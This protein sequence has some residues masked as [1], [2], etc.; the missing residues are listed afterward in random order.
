M[1]PW[2]RLLVALLPAL[3]SG[4]PAAAQEV[5]FH[6]LKDRTVVGSIKAIRRDSG[7]ST[8]YVVSSYSQMAVVKKQV[9]RSNLAA[10]YRQG[11]PYSC[12][13][14][15]HLNGSLRDS[16]YMRTQGSL[17]SCYRYPDERFEVGRA[18]AWTTSR[19]YFEEPAGQ[20]TVFVESVL[21]ECRLQSTAPGVYVLELPGNRTNTYRYA[22]GRLM[23]VQV[24]QPLLK[25][26]FRRA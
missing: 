13:S 15:F 25:L 8:I 10:E 6:I 2:F 18:S 14:S 12:F 17:L 7:A 20:S 11:R 16:S 3:A 22:G 21:K 1:H 26:T 9:V 5:G 24:D 4:I 23:E 19:M